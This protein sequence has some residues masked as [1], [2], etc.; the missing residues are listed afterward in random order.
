[1]ETIIFDFSGLVCVV[2]N[3]QNAVVT[4]KCKAVPIGLTSEF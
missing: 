1:M 2:E 3:Q 4:G